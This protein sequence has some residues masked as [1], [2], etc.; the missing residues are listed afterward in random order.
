MAM[1]R[2]Q[3]EAMREAAISGKVQ[4]S[5]AVSIEEFEGMEVSIPKT[6]RGSVYG[7]QDGEYT[8]E[9]TSV[10]IDKVASTGNPWVRFELKLSNGFRAFSDIVVAGKNLETIDVL[11]FRLDGM[12]LS[13]YCI[14]QEKALTIAE[15]LR[16]L[17]NLQGSKVSAWLRWTDLDNGGKLLKSAVSTWKV[18]S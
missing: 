12:R 17:V 1:T 14:E 9:I 7:V 10:I 18:A 11:V 2:D 3:I 13:D 6:P 8:I 4:A 15:I 16:F 5:S